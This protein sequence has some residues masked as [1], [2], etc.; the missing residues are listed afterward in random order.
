MISSF[1]Y[2]QDDELLAYQTCFDLVENE[3]Q[4]FLT[5]VSKMQA[6]TTACQSAHVM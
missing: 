1:H 4:S 3:M 2:M 5:K 6:I